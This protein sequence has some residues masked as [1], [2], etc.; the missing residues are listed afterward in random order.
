M[1]LINYLTETAIKTIVDKIID[2]S[3]FTGYLLHMPNR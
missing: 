1:T 3:F 2:Q